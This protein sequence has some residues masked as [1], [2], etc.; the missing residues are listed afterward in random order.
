MQQKSDRLTPQELNKQKYDNPLVI[1]IY[2]QHHKLSI[3][4]AIQ[5]SIAGWLLFCCM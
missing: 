4:K 5:L 2:C 1:P 3:N